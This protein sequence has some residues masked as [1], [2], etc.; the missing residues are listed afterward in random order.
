MYRRKEHK[1][2]HN[3][4][5][6]RGMHPNVARHVV[7]NSGAGIID[8]FKKHKNAIFNFGRAG[9]NLFK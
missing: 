2:M 8:F 4:L 9:Y 6:G 5:V 3:Y 7:L 1:L